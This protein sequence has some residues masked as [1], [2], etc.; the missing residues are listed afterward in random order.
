MLE[1]TNELP[2][3]QKGVAI[4]ILSSYYP[5][6]KVDGRAASV[7]L[8][9]IGQFDDV[10]LSGKDVLYFHHIISTSVSLVLHRTVHTLPT[11]AC[12]NCQKWGTQRDIYQADYL[13]L[14]L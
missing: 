14:H 11:S 7:G 2:L 6:T 13:Y 8:D 4:L 9:H 5:H 12:I 10:Y 1:G 3:R